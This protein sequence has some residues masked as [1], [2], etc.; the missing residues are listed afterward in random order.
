MENKETFV[1]A[2]CDLLVKNKAVEEKE[3]DALKKVFKESEQEYFDNF[4]IEEG[5]VEEKDLLS[6]LSQYYKVPAFDARGYFFETFLLH[7][8]PKDFLL[9]NCFIPLEVDENMLVVVASHPE[10]PGLES[11]MR[12]FV[13]YEIEFFVGLSE[14]IID[15]IE[16]YYDKSLTLDVEDEDRD[17]D[18][19]M[20]LEKEAL[21]KLQERELKDGDMIYRDEEDE[22]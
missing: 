10:L 13:S 2:L 3:A 22:E 8:F 7:R 21:G 18:E 20:R 17:M 9:R 14:H 11:A 1:Q 19:E 16:E 4:L 12:E 15:A 5:L 6:A